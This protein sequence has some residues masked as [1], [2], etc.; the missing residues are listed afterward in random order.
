[1]QTATSNNL[2]QL[3]REDMM[4]FLAGMMPAVNPGAHHWLI[5]HVLE[6]LLHR[7]K[8]RVIF[9]LPPQ[10]GKSTTT[11]EAFPAWY[12][13][14]YPSHPVMSVSC[15]QGLATGFGKKAR[16]YIASPLYQAIFPATRLDPSSRAKDKFD[17]TA[18]GA[19]NA[20]G[21][22]GTGVGKPAKLLIIDDLV[23]NRHEANSPTVKE[24]NIAN[25]KSV[26]R[27]RVHPDGLI[28]VVNTRWGLG[29]FTDWLIN[30]NA[31]E[32]WHVVAIPAEAGLNDP[33]G[34]KPGEFL[35]MERY[36][37]QEVQTIKET[38][39]SVEWEAQ[40]Q[41]C[42]ILG[43]DTIY[44]P[45]TFKFYSKPYPLS[46]M[47]IIHS[48]DLTFGSNNPKRKSSHVCGQVWGYHPPTKRKLLLWQDRRQMGFWASVSAILQMR[49]TW[50]AGRVLIENK[51]NG[52]ATSD[53][54][55]DEVD[56]LEM[57][58]FGVSSK[59]DRA[60]AVQPQFQ[61]GE[62]WFPD[63]KIAGNEW[64]KPLLTE[65]ERFPL[66]ATNDCVDTMN[67]AL[68]VIDEGTSG[69]EVSKARRS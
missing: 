37:A 55:E 9:N 4:A 24:Q 36:S 66:S 23:K 34:R 44:D 40:Y 68:I 59:E 51:A 63:P 53:T 31:H 64:V 58:S 18:G 43:T 3:M 2:L 30:E 29:D 14:H 15:T 46:S 25:Y 69:Y 8:R 22:D 39:G 6:D 54:I 45:K 48:W 61:R 27:P 60:N 41:Q 26:W 21:R 13:G 12:L 11:T 17:T 35:W 49:Q 62:V 57:I 32:D 1:V 65:L 47:E 33:L 19:Y 67:Q 7:R 10:F 56:G 16:D 28:L 42:P 50:P 5:C 20:I 38:V 52:P